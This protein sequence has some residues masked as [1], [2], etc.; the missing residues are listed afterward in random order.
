[1]LCQI[2]PLLYINFHGPARSLECEAPIVFQS[3]QSNLPRRFPF[4]V[5]GEKI[6]SISQANQILAGQWYI[7]VCTT[8]Y[9]C[10]ELVGYIYN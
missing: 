4:T 3:N 8:S 10:G 7:E 9:P 5:F 2:S 6:L 1:M